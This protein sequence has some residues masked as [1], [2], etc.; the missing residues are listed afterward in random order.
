MA[1][2]G[3]FARASRGTEGAGLGRRVMLTQTV[4]PFSI[5][6]RK[7]STAVSIPALSLVGSY[8]WLLAGSRPSAFL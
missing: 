1:G 5:E 2:S 8:G 3:S 4:I 7:S 6:L